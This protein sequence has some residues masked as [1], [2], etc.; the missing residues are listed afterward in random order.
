MATH[1]SILAWRIPWI[2]EPDRLQ[3][4]GSQSHSHTTEATEHAGIHSIPLYT[5]IT[6]SSL[7]IHLLMDTW[8]ASTSWLWYIRL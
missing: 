2:E 6:T 1:A 3:M 5:Y 7:S 8:V 4:M